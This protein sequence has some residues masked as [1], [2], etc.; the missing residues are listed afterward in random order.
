MKKLIFSL[1]LTL[2]ALAQESRWH[3]VAS[4]LQKSALTPTTVQQLDRAA[5]KEINKHFPA[6][7]LGEAWDQHPEAP[8]MQWSTQAAA[9]LLKDPWSL[10]LSPAS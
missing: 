7:S 3:D 2:P 5:L 10:K 6:S 1:L 4:A 8:L 9:E